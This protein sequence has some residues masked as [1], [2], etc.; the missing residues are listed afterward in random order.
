MATR[1]VDDP[2]EPDLLACL[3]LDALRE[4]RVLARLHVVA[5]AFDIGERAMITPDLGGQTRH[6]AIG[7]GIAFRNRKNEAINVI[8]HF[9]S[10]SV[11]P[12][13]ACG[14]GLR[15]IRGGACSTCC[16][17]WCTRCSR[18][19]PPAGTRAHRRVHRE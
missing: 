15:I 13:S 9:E 12:D 7:C 17:P 8:R 18:G 11:A 10:P 2:R 6:L 16:R 4:G 5:D 19:G 14:P 1:L 3:E